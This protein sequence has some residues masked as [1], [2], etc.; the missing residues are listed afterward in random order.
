M[1]KCHLL[2]V[3]LLC[4]LPTAFGLAQSNAAAQIALQGQPSVNNQQVEVR[5]T[6]SDQQGLSPA[7]LLPANI[8]LSE[9]ASEDL[10]SD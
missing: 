10:D 2:I 5:F 4:C 8:K 3:I 1:R 6:V 7:D 9:P